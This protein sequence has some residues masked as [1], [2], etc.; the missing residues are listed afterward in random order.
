M[1]EALLTKVATAGGKYLVK[2]AIFLTADCVIPGS[3]EVLRTVDKLV[4]VGGALTSG[5]PDIEEALDNAGGF[6][7]N[8]IYP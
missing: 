6:I 3:G 8:I 4:R 7:D 1:M 2:Q 5:M